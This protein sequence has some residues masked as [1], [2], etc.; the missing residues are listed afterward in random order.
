[1]KKTRLLLQMALWLMAGGVLVAAGGCSDDPDEEIIVTPEPEP[2][3]EPDPEPDPVEITITLPE[4]LSVDR[5]QSATVSV[6]LSGNV[7][8]LPEWTCTSSDPSAVAAEKVDAATMTVRGVA[9]GAATV[10]VECSVDGAAFAAEM[11]VTV[12]PGALRVLAIGNSFSQ[13]AVEQYLYELAASAGVEMVVGNM[14]IG[15]CDLDKH[16]GYLQSDQGAYAY[17]KVVDGVKTERTGV[18]FS[19]AF[20]DE[21]WDYISLQQ[22]SGKSGQYS[23]FGSLRGMVDG[24]RT[25]V[26]DAELLWHQ[27]WAYAQSSTHADFPNYG[28]DQLTMYNAIVAASR[29]V[30]NDYSEFAKLI[31]S[32]TAIQNARGTYVGDVFNRDGYH[33]EVTYGRYTAACTWFEAL[34]GIDATTAAYQ[35]ATVS[36]EMGALARAAAHAAVQQPDAVSV[37]DGF[38]KPAIKEGPLA[39]PVFVDFGPNAHAPEPWNVVTSYLPADSPM[40]LRDQSGDFVSVTLQVL[41]GF[42]ANYAGVS[43]ESSQSAITAA[44]YEF[45][46]DAW[47]DGLLVAGN[48]GEGDVGPGRLRIGGLTPGAAYDFT[49]LAVRYNGS[50]DARISSYRLTGSAQSAAQQVKTGLKV[51]G[52]GFATFADAPF[53][54]Y[55]ATFA[56]VAPDAEGNVVVEVRGIDTGTAAEGHINA[57]VIAPAQ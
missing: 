51:G 50:R 54:E 17:R 16:Y 21:P 35:P 8:P 48:K 26:P 33:L 18:S 20:A 28:S 39:A 42:T 34:T 3:P 43:G 15:G 29:S 7:E 38:D 23:T 5:R 36:D 12:N 9:A 55:A 30:M 47:K 22:V 27:T 40:W 31:P 53:D 57:L 56:G 52:T 45:P 44:G 49:I 2:E 10:R 24:V 41:D 32:G 4:T 6:A 1:M 11:A 19:Q 25:A 37:L 13:D 14:Y 46:I